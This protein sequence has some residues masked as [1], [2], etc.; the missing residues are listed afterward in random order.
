VVQA[1]LMNIA[2]Y[3]EVE[4]QIARLADGVVLVEVRLPSGTGTLACRSEAIAIS[5]AKLMI[6]K[7]NLGMLDIAP[8]RNVR[9]RRSPWFR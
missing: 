9:H 8:D 3:H 2:I 6:D 1:A 5:K 4:V 7:D